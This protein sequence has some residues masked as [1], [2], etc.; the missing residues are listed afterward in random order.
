M[1]KNIKL[2]TKMLIGI[3]LISLIGLSGVGLTTYFIADNT[4]S[5]FVKKDL[6]NKLS[7]AYSYVDTTLNSEV[8]SYLKTRADDTKLIVENYYNL[9]NTRKMKENDA[10]DKIKNL[11][12]DENF[13]KIGDTGY[14][15]VASSKSIVIF[16]PKI[17]A[18]TDLSKNDI[19]NK[20]S[21][22]KNGYFEYPWKNPDEN[23]ER[24]KAVALSYF[25][26][27]DMVIWCTSYISEFVSWLD[28]DKLSK[29]ILDIKI[30]KTGYAYIINSR[31]DLII[32]PSMAGQNIYN[33][34][35]EKGRFFIQEICSKKNG[36]I[37]YPW[38][39]PDDKKARDKIVFYKY[40]KDLDWIIAVGS[41]LD[42]FYAPMMQLGIYSIAI[43][44]I[45]LII[46]LIISYQLSNYFIK[47]LLVIKN[48]LMNIAS[49]SEIADLTKRINININDEI[50]DIGFVVNS[51]L[52][53]LNNS[54]YEVDSA[55]KIIKV[56]ADSSKE[57][58]DKSSNNFGQIKA[59]IQKIENQTENSA[60]GIEQLSAALEEMDRNIES[61]LDFMVLQASS[62]EEG[63]SS[64]E[65]MVRNIDNTASMSVK[66]HEISNNLNNV[67]QEGGIAVKDSI[68]SVKEVAEYSQQILK[69]LSLITNIAKQTNLLAMNA[70][71]EAAHAG[72]AG[73]GFAIVADEI[74]RL[75]EDTN[76]NA[77]DI[78]DVVGTIV[79]RIDDSVKLSEK[80]GIALETIMNYSR[81][82]VQI[83]NQ[84]NVAMV[85]QNNG[86]KEILKAT[87]ELVRITEE[88]KTSMT[89][90]KKATKEFN[91]TLHDLRNLSLE[92]KDNI[93]DHI[94]NI[95]ELIVFQDNILKIINENQNQATNLQN[96]VNKFIVN[97]TKRENTGLKLVE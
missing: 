2:K 79:T 49:D 31:G 29:E 30:G 23:Q 28:F 18:G 76:K 47:G 20:G 89:E 85:E 1:L 81:Q 86:A 33:S 78:G 35:D 6:S 25:E 41:Y 92:N 69:L 38:K 55:S 74:R 91:Q 90:Q 62:V 83:I 64:I 11:V 63:A 52:Q 56:S 16:H 24:M 5:D 54:I 26:P 60:S 94:K 82:N 95:T 44:M 70:A 58:I 71:I 50:G 53:K 39:N 84:L 73:K 72:E 61:I 37:I 68:K 9:Y 66:T 27:W 10:L 14:I 19:I 80:T 96:L 7:M 13:G 36:Q 42:E 93:I 48:K 97:E 65:E 45:T 34:K 8:R 88:V 22:I 32:H 12:L 87:Q 59:N 75:S 40:Y 3:G 67:A 15:A 77:K 17:P 51:I 4:I 43:I 57:I 21:Q 46:I